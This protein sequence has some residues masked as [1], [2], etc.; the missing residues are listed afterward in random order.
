MRPDRSPVERWFMRRGIPHF[1]EGYAAGTDI[2]TRVTPLLTLVFVT[3]V[4]VLSFGDRFAGLVQALAVVGALAL[5]L[6]AVAVVNR[7][8]GLR[9]LQLPHDVGPWELALFVFVPA[10]AA[11]VFGTDPVLEAS[12]LFIGNWCSW[13]LR[14][15]PP[16]MDWCR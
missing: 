10:L 9:P 15:S 5:T 16:A 2:L 13:D 1:I 11:L 12:V 6:G 7:L 4:I 8:R 3:E 14:T